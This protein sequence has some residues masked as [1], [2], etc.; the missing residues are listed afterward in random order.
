MQG[1][2]AEEVRDTLRAPHVVAAVADVVSQF[3]GVVPAFKT[4][5]HRDVASVLHASAE[6]LCFV[7][8]CSTRILSKLDGSDVTL[9]GESTEVGF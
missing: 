8:A 4:V 9:P 7:E 3:A 6:Q 1:R 5:R 2:S